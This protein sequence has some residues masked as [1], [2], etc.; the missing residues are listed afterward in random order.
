MKELTGQELQDEL[1]RCV[2]FLENHGYE[3]IDRG[4]YPRP[5]EEVEEGCGCLGGCMSCLMLNY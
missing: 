2:E 4:T 1:E 3:V 5:E